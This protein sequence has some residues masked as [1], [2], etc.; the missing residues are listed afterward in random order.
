MTLLPNPV[1]VDNAWEFLNGATS[2]K[3]DFIV[4]TEEA[5]SILEAEGK[6]AVRCAWD[7]VGVDRSI[8]HQASLSTATHMLHNVP[9]PRACDEFASHMGA[10]A[11]PK[12]ASWIHQHG[13]DRNLGGTGAQRCMAK[14]CL[15]KGEVHSDSPVESV[16]CV[17]RSK[18]NRNVFVKTAISRKPSPWKPTSKKKTA[19]TKVMRLRRILWKSIDK[20]VD[21]NDLVEGK[22]KEHDEHM[23]ANKYYTK[24]TKDGEG[25][26]EEITGL[27]DDNEEECE[28]GESQGMHQQIMNTRAYK[29]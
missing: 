12:G 3:E 5:Y 1:E 15:E 13:I 8:S 24:Y 6:L 26:C 21:Y 22:N 7:R 19:T 11:H 20:S 18:S 25:V 9:G 27:F 16:E 29:Y 17:E 10:L 14:K 23:K 2:L 28:R 4:N